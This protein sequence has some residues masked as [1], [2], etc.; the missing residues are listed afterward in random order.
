MKATRLL[1]AS[2]LESHILFNGKETASSL[3]PGVA[4]DEE[5]YD[6]HAAQLERQVF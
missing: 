4:K 3:P 6:Y 1:D 2:N 5:S